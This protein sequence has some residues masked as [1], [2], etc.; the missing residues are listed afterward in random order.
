MAKFEGL[1]IDIDLEL[2]NLDRLT[3]ELGQTTQ[4]IK[5]IPDY[6]QIRA[7]GSILHDFYTGLEKIFERIALT[8]DGGVPE[9]DDWH[10]QLLRRMLANIPDRRPALFTKNVG[11]SLGEYLGFR[12]LFRNIYGFELKWERMSPLVE[13]FPSVFKEVESQLMKFINFISE[14]QN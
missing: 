9:G 13:K 2:Q 4:E 10:I 5:E 7:I 6:T 3:M 1:I 8:I 11:E 14:I 12:H